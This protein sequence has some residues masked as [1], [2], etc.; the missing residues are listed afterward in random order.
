MLILAVLVIA[1]GLPSHALAHGALR[2]SEPANGAHLAVAPR[3]LRLTF[4]ESVELAVARL[5]LV[6]PDSAAVVLGPLTLAVDSSMVLVAPIQGRLKA[7]S[8]TVVWQIAGA[9]GHPVRGRY[10][11]VIAPGAQG[12]AAPQGPTAPGQAAPP[13]T[14][15][16]PV[17][18]P[19][20]PGFDAE[21]PLYVAVRWLTY[22]GLLGVIGSLAFRMAVLPLVARHDA[23]VGAALLE[24]ASARAARI[25]LASA[26][27]V[28]LAA[29]LRLYAQSYALHGGSAALSPF[30][31]GTMLSRTLWGW[32]WLLQ[33]AGTVLA[34]AGF[35]AARRSTSTATSAAET[36]AVDTGVADPP[37]A[38]EGG[39]IALARPVAVSPGRAR[40]AE[41]M[42]AGWLLA[43]LGGVALAFAPALSG[44]AASVPRRAGL[45]ILSDGVH[46][47][48][49]GGWVGGLLLLVLA[50]VPAAMALPRE[51]RGSAVAALVNAFSVTALVFAG[52]LTLTGVYAAW[53]HLGR[54]PALWETGYG[55]TLLLKL[56]VLSV[57]FGTGA[58]NWLRLRPALGREAGATRL[59]RS[60]TVEI[61]AGVVVL[62]V[63]AVLVAT[64]TPAGM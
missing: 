22:L 52:A 38:A 47:L 39:A 32:G 16:N 54:I 56:G 1:L 60:A 43:T 49:A 2:R 44:H 10:S 19:T 14:H 42:S 24:P 63:T 53:L 33:A 48:G 13:A 57:V 62:L 55:R 34:L 37:H 4:N 30:L 31:I 8:Y 51:E 59:R 35:A 28:A 64:A 21:S 50:G 7:G 15:H 25:G 29:V 20:G 27:V 3:E 36:G 5:Q 6:G 26:A 40:A 12:L 11:F 61:V 18:L 46:V 45:A 41:H 58:Y 23:S 17:S 9:D